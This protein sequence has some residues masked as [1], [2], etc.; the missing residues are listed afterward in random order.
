M[1]INIRE[2]LIC[3]GERGRKRQRKRE[4]GKGQLGESKE[5]LGFSSS[6]SY[7]LVGAPKGLW[8]LEISSSSSSFS[9]LASF[10]CWV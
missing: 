10:S 6:S 8:K 5:R 4:E 2:R 1:C 7:L 3:M 9:L